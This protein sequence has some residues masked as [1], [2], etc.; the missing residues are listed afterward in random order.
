MSILTYAYVYLK[1]AYEIKIITAKT[2][3]TNLTKYYLNIF[4][5]IYMNIYE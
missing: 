3:K 1:M 2:L 4:L 5:I